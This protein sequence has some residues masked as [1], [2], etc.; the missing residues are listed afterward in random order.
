MV[1][2]KAHEVH[3]N[4]SKTSIVNSFGHFFRPEGANGPINIMSTQKFSAAEREAI[5]LA[6]G[7][8]CAYTG[9][10]L[11]VSNFHID[12]II[13][14]SLA[15]DP[16]AFKDKI[17][18]L[19]LPTDFNIHGYENLLPCCPRANFQKSNLILCQT[20]YFLSIAAA[21]KK[22]VESN[23]T[24]IKKR[25]D[26]GKAAILLQ[27]HIER[28]DLTSDKVAE[29]FQQHSEQPEAIFELIENMQFAN[30]D[31]V[32]SIAKA[33]IES[34]WDLPVW[35]GEY[36]TDGLPFTNKKDEQ[37]FV[38]TCREYESACEQGYLAVSNA[39]LKMSVSFH[40]RCE[41]L[42]SLQSATTPQQSF[43]SN[44]KVGVVDLN[45]L[46]FS[47]FPWIGDKPKRKEL[48]ATYQSKVNDGMLVVKSVSQN[49]LEIV[50]PKDMGQRLIEVVR[51]DFNGDGI[52]NIL[53]F[54]YC[55]ATE[56]TLGFGGSRI[57][58]RKSTDGKFE[59]VE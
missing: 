31:E 45:L 29:I 15:K 36:Y 43:I 10:S 50:A 49:S 39:V 53:L 7:K 19:N 9:E 6:H 11:D 14:E 20:H 37:I 59:I 41:L 26:S 4:S 54:E 33:D 17:A 16:V 2:Y 23:L 35:L 13:P 57:L 46:P 42:K 18:K 25:E 38:R 58:T 52:E 27:Q 44:P 55:F 12:H 28:G 56:G 1:C 47:L 51:A 40:Q 30:G 24:R 22:E 3:V 34:L 48:K 21:K 8:K 5:H 32:K